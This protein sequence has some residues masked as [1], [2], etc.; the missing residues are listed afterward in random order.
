VASLNPGPNF[1]CRQSVR[2]GGLTRPPVPRAAPAELGRTTTGGLA[3]T[4]SSPRKGRDHR[5]GWLTPDPA[6]SERTS[7]RSRGRDTR[8]EAT[9]TP[10]G[11]GFNS[12]R[13]HHSPW[14]WSALSG[15]AGCALSRRV[16]ALEPC[17]LRGVAGIGRPG[18][19]GRVPSWLS[20]R[21]E[22]AYPY[23]E[24]TLAR[25]R[26]LVD[27][28]GWRDPAWNA[29]GTLEVVH[30]KTGLGFVLVSPPPIALPQGVDHPPEE[31]A[32]PLARRE[33][34]RMLHPDGA[35]QRRCTVSM[36]VR[37]PP[38]TPARRTGIELAPRSRLVPGMRWRGELGYPTSCMG[39]TVGGGRG[40]PSD[41]S[42]AITS[43]TTSHSSR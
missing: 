23:A 17:V 43:S 29:H 38:P 37:F 11:T 19:S 31:S 36:P 6:P 39:R 22:S 34:H 12:P 28:E 42:R 16:A 40:R 4:E 15:G 27:G 1:T 20:E 9:S 25:F 33:S 30:E 13:L 24:E 32:P 21:P 2:N 14:T 41:V 5:G 10:V 7:A 35:G 3:P 18:P 26:R 8:V